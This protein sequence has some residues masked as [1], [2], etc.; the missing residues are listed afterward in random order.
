LVFGGVPAL[1]EPQY[2]QR[3]AGF[4]EI[5]I[6]HT[7]SKQRVKLARE[8][9]CVAANAPEHTEINNNEDKM[10]CFIFSLLMDYIIIWQGGA[11]K[12]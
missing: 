11:K 12:K 8:H 9:C 4:D 10:R 2:W 1:S 3:A 7:E 5:F 6:A